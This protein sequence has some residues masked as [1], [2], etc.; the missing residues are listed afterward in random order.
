MINFQVNSLSNLLFVYSKT[1]FISC[2]QTDVN[3]G[4]SSGHKSD[5][6]LFS[7]KDLYAEI[8]LRQGR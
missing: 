8:K 1:L 5:E 6:E 2:I 3:S 7:P 4:R